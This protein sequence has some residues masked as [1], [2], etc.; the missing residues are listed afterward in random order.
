[1]IY[2]INAGYAGEV[3]KAP[4]NFMEAILDARDIAQYQTT[5]YEIELIKCMYPNIEIVHIEPRAGLKLAPYDFTPQ[6]AEEVI[7]ESYRHTR[8]LL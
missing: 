4:R 1:V 7:E 3:K 2:A 8:R 6:R 5:R